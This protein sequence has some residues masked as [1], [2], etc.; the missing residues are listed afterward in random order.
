MEGKVPLLDV[1]DSVFKTGKE[2]VNKELIFK[3]WC[4]LIRLNTG[5]MEWDDFDFI[6]SGSRVMID[7]E[8]EKIWK[9]LCYRSQ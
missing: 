1:S 2:K 9:Y 4:I 3:L 6:S 7:T 5:N 8:Q